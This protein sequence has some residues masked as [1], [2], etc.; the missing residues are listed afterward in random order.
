MFG[1]KNIRFGCLYFSY[2][3]CKLV[4]I[5]LIFK[6]DYMAHSELQQYLMY[7]CT[8]F[9][10]KIISQQNVWAKVFLSQC[11]YI[12]LEYFDQIE[13][14]TRYCYEEIHENSKSAHQ[15][16]NEYDVG[17]SFWWY[18]TN[19]QQIVHEICNLISSKM[20]MLCH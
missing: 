3:N 4:S 17:K 11:I 20:L 8:N 1:Y 18:K 2:K 6:C 10:F 15:H 12:R 13:N 7:S 14:Q 9:E 19:E 5:N 16:C